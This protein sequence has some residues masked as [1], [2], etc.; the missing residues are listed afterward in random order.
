MLMKYIFLRKRL[1]KDL[2]S[3]RKLVVDHMQQDTWNKYFTSAIAYNRLFPT[4]NNIEKKM[5]QRQ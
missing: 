1:F 4:E 3:F 2:P 5:K